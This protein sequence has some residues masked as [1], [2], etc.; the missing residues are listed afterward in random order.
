MWGIAT[1]SHQSESVAFSTNAR[2]CLGS[3]TDSAYRT[4]PLIVYLCG[5]KDGQHVFVEIVATI[6]RC[7]R[8]CVEFKSLK[9][10]TPF[11]LKRVYVAQ[12]MGYT[13]GDHITGGRS[14]ARFG[15]PLGLQSVYL[16]RTTGRAHGSVAR[17]SFRIR[18]FLH[19]RPPDR[20]WIQAGLGRQ[21]ANHQ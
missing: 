20:W 11:V 3:C 5:N 15:D 8:R 16:V 2:R 19:L 13:Y 12:S 18:R 10:K 7:L 17:R 21:T 9:S 4:G 6:R 1:S 14:V